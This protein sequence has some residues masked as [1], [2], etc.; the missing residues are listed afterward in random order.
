MLG[1]TRHVTKG[2]RQTQTF[3]S[4][5][6]TI[7]SW[8]MPDAIFFNLFGSS[9]IVLVEWPSENSSLMIDE[10]VFY[11]LHI[12]GISFNRMLNSSYA[13]II[14]DASFYSRWP[15]IQTSTPEKHPWYKRL[16]MFSCE[17][18][19]CIIPM[20]SRPMVTGKRWQKNGKSCKE[21]T[22]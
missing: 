18:N 13:Y 1:G 14:I 19:I 6:D 12:K 9:W 10:F 16:W 11:K 15:E 3:S 17:W 4:T 5:M 2:E 7:K 22:S 20:P 21:Y 8:K